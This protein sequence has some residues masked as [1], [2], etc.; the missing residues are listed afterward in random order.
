MTLV[1]LTASAALKEKRLEGLLAAR[2]ADRAVLASVVEDARLLGSLELAGVPASWEDVRRPDPEAP[3]EVRRLRQ[4]FR[5]VAKDAPLDRGALR[6]WHAAV[7]GVPSGWRAEPRT[8]EGAPPAP[9]G[10]IEG[11]LEILEGWLASESVARLA[12]AQAGALVLARVV[13]ILPFDD[14]NG[15]VSRLAATH[16]AVRA[17]GRAPIL[18]GGD[19]VRLKAALQAAFALDMAPLAALLDEAGERSLDVMIQALEAPAPR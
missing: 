7:V 19:G 11:R 12:P 2:V 4:A 10:A 8:R 3:G 13:E 5:S 14:G 9:P 18:V 6:A 15:R 17:G 16:A 1:R